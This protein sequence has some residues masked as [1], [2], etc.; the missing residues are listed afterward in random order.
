MGLDH[1]ASGLQEFLAERGDHLLRTAM[2][3]SGSR[4]AGE[5]LLQTA[6]ERMLRHWR[7]ID[8][9]PE[10]Y[11]RR[12]IYNL[13]TDGWR[14]KARWRASLALLRG[15]E[16]GIVPDRSLQVEQRDELVRLLLRLPPAQR[17]AIVLRYWEDMSEAE[18]A[19]VLGCSASTVSSAIARG[20]RRL[21]ELSGATSAAVATQGGEP[22]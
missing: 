6:L 22:R 17:A 2:L 13:A 11:L 15:V 8:G 1:R 7:T 12:T 21:R 10:G 18:A 3:L 19:E 9:D 20:L 5:D 14:R 4:D 16:D